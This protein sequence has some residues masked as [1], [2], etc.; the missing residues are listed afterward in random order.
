MVYREFLNKVS[1]EDFAD[2]ILENAIFTMACVN[3]DIFT[4]C[5]NKIPSENCKKCLL[6]MLQSKME[7]TI[8]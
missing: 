4:S 7:P 8:E 3:S 2:I 5:K 6:K 1:N